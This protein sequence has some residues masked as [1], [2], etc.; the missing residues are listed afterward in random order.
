ML[1]IDI[2]VDQCWLYVLSRGILMLSYRSRTTP[3]PLLGT[4]PDRL[5]I[6]IASPI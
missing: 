5:S 2:V 4:I 6:Y 3:D 1:E